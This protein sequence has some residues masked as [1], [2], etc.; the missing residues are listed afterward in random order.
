MIDRTETPTNMPDVGEDRQPGTVAPASPRRAADAWRPWLGSQREQDQQAAERHDPPGRRAPRC[1]RSR[2]RPGESS[3]ATRIGRPGGQREHPEDRVPV[4]DRRRR[5][6]TRRRR[7][8]PAQAQAGQH[9]HHRRQCGQDVDDHLEGHGAKSALV[10]FAGRHRRSARR[11]PVSAASHLGVP[12]A[13]PRAGRGARRPRTS[14]SRGRPGR[15][16]PGAGRRPR[17]GGRRARRRRAGRRTPR[18]CGAP[19]PAATTATPP[20]ASTIRTAKN[21][22]IRD[23]PTGRR[24]WRASTISAHRLVDVV[25][26][27]QQVEVGLGDLALGEHGV[28]QPV[29]QA[30]PVRRADQHDRER[31]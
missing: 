28:A 3:G 5:P 22:I 9:D 17:A 18:P 13:Q 14:G 12:H 4:E 19:R 26:E 27:D 20:R 31:R 8:L 30:L 16:G 2:R 1:R 7:R 10:G 6:A 24:P 23:R 29:E 15:S 25:G 21:H 11:V